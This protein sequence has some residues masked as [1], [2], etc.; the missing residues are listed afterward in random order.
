MGKNAADASDVVRLSLSEAGY[1]EHQLQ[2]WLAQ[3]PTRLGLGDVTVDAQE[4]HY[5]DAG[6]LDI[7]ASDGQRVY[8]VEVLLGEVDPSHGFRVLDYWAR[9]RR[10]QP[11]KTH[12]AVLVCES[13]D[14][15]YRPVLETLADY[16]PLIVIRCR[17]TPGETG[18]VP[19]CEVVIASTD[20][21]LP[22]VSLGVLP[23][24]RTK[25]SWQEASTPAAWLAVEKL[26][27]YAKSEL[28]SSIQ[29]DFSLSSRISLR[30][31]RRLW[32]SIRPTGQGITIALPDPDG[33]TGTT[34]SL[35]FEDLSAIT[36][37]AGVGL[38]WQPNSNA[39]AQ[40]VTANLL[41]G[42]LDSREVRELLRASWKIILPESDPYSG[43][44]DY[45]QE[46]IEY[47]SD[48]ERP[49]IEPY[50]A[51]EYAEASGYSG[52]V[53][54]KLVYSNEDDEADIFYA[55]TEHDWDTPAE[56]QDFVRRVLTHHL[57]RKPTAKEI[58]SLLKGPAAKC[59]A[60]Q[61]WTLDVSTLARWLWENG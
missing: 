54:A 14:G 28:A 44:W 24:E 21:N 49:D 33:M 18:A 60:G 20:L 9:N 57:K 52:E 41:P 50:Y 30:Y 15:R 4:L 13:V 16:L 37:R 22:T 40:P 61:L 43:D 32:A 1:S 47:P 23:A 38:A 55:T 46:A 11:E 59:E 6:R 35:A 19:V 53:Y 51:G 12:V 2:D 31:G 45:T 39:G 8:T 26:L 5:G 42:D 25:Q 56:K 27:R 10:R 34:P 36:A 3:D 29:V 48:P 58:K 17:T 7:L